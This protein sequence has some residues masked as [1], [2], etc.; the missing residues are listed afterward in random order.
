MKE[1]KL[2]HGLGLEIASLN[3]AGGNINDSYQVVSS[4]GVD[5][6]KAAQEYIDACS[7]IKELMDDYI[8]LVEKDVSDMNAMMLIAKQRDSK[9]AHLF[10]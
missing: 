6:L 9:L 8:A 10:K 2:S 7:A 4:D 1:F 5:T 3:S